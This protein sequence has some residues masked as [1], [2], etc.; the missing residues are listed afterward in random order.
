MNIG[1]NVQFLLPDYNTSRHNC[2]VILYHFRNIKFLY[3]IT[4][5]ISRSDTLIRDFKIIFGYIQT[6]YEIFFFIFYFGNKIKKLSNVTATNR[7]CVLLCHIM[8]DCVL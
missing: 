7:H 6:N 1:H 5:Y 3:F 2:I 8:Y 4:T